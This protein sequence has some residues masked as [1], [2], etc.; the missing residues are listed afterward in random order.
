MYY[1]GKK[2]RSS[3]PTLPEAQGPK[4]IVNEALGSTVNIVCIGES[5]MS[6]VGA[7]T[8]EEAIAGTFAKSISA[9]LSRAVN[10]KV[11]AKKGYTAAKATELLL[12]QIKDQEVDLFLVALGGNDAF[13]LSSPKKWKNDCK[14]FIKV[15]RFKYPHTPILFCNMPPIKGFPAFTPLIKFTIGNLVEMHGEALAKLVQEFDEVF[16]HD[17]II[18][19]EK[20]SKH[21]K[22]DEDP[23]A[24]F[25]DGV[26]PSVLTYQTWA[27]DMARF[28]LTKKVILTKK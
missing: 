2:I 3:V 21:L 9:H 16:Y 1:D 5:T 20:W 24:F 4:G 6:G 28:L 23:N 27:K 7:K 8:H 19:L 18:K 10:W 12:P 22:I 11:Y 26:H 15:L 25:S 13:K 14:F 17:E